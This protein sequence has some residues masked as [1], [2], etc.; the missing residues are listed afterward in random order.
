M[1]DVA[2]VSS[3]SLDVFSLAVPSLGLFP[4]LPLF[5]RTGADSGSV[6]LAAIV[7]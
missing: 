1:G 4:A 2:R 6:L 7:A 5:R 3:L